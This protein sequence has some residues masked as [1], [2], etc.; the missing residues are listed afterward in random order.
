MTASTTLHPQQ[1]EQLLQFFKG[2]GIALILWQK[3]VPIEMH[4][5]FDLNGEHMPFNVTGE[6]FIQLP[7]PDPQTGA[8]PVEIVALE[9]KSTDPINVAVG[10]DNPEQWQV[11]LMLEPVDHTGKLNLVA[12]QMP[13]LAFHNVGPNQETL[14]ADPD[15]AHEFGVFGCAPTFPRTQAFG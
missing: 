5:F 13:N 8:A 10:L 15:F 3:L 6:A 2:K 12:G 9:L 4:G 11:T 1:M 14:I 7:P